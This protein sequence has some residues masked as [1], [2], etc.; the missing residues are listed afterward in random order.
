MRNFALACLRGW[1]FVLSRECKCQLLLCVETFFW[2]FGFY[3]TWFK[4]VLPYWSRNH[5]TERSKKYKENCQQVMWRRCIVCGKLRRPK[6]WH[7]SWRGL[8]PQGHPLLYLSH[9]W[10]LQPPSGVW[11]DF[12]SCWIPHLTQS[13]CQVCWVIFWIYGVY[14]TSNQTLLAPPMCVLKAEN[15]VLLYN[16]QEMALLS[17]LGY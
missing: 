8:A 11:L 14:S 5:G 3:S 15:T 12:A 2:S 16:Y 4:S 10:N 13:W 6:R 7:T 1:E 17:L 9:K